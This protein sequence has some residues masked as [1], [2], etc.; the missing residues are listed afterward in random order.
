[1]LHI[2]QRAK[3]S[4]L[5]KEAVSNEEASAWSTQT[6]DDPVRLAVGHELERTDT[7]MYSLNLHESDISHS[8]QKDITPHGNSKELPTLIQNPSEL[9]SL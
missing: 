6:L 5:L 4:L 1:M 3:I 9:N 2:H 7:S 8:Q